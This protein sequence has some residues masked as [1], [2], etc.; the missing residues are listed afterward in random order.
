MSRCWNQ[1]VC[2]GGEGAICYSSCVT[3]IN[4]T[5]I[6]ETDSVFSWFTHA[7][8][9]PFNWVEYLFCETWTLGSIF[10]SPHLVGP[11][12]CGSCMS[13]LIG[14]FGGAACFYR[15]LIGFASPLSRIL[16][17]SADIFSMKNVFHKPEGSAGAWNT[18]PWK[19]CRLYSHEPKRPRFREWMPDPAA[20]LGGQWGAMA[21]SPTGNDMTE[22]VFGGR[23]IWEKQTEKWGGNS[24]EAQGPIVATIQWWPKEAWSGVEPAGMERSRWLGEAAKMKEPLSPAHQLLLPNAKGPLYQLT[25]MAPPAPS[26]L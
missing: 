19:K 22:E 11:L 18:L 2:V 10:F 14:E 21:S 23:R 8:S 26:S 1:N 3:L 16:T 20:W 4:R 6:L 7:H 25:S 15:L 24:S 12:L 17:G 9:Q 5:Y 13:Q